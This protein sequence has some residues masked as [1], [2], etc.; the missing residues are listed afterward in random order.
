MLVAVSW[1]GAFF[2]LQPSLSSIGSLMTFGWVLF[3]IPVL[4]ALAFIDLEHFLLPDGLIG[5]GVVTTIFY[6]I[7]LHLFDG[8]WLTLW[9]DGAAALGLVLF[10]WLLILLTRGKGM[11]VGDVKLAFLVGL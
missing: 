7:T 5:V 3:L 4:V 1:V 6:R 9:I 11:G 8:G 2:W 10:F